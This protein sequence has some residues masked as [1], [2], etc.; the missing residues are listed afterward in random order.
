[1]NFARLPS[2]LFSLFPGL[3]FIPIR[4]MRKVRAH[5]ELD[6]FEKIL[7]SF[8]PITSVQG[9]PIEPAQIES[10]CKTLQQEIINTL[11]ALATGKTKS[12]PVSSVW[13]DVKPVR[14]V[15]LKVNDTGKVTLSFTEANVSNTVLEQL[16]AAV[17]SK[18][19]K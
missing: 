18:K 7:K 16:M 10:A 3:S 6:E 11:D 5:Q 8:E 14:G 12:E 4:F 19:H 9:Q 2:C 1:M 17:A 15:N 13:R